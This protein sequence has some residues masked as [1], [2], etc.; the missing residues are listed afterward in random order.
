MS[1]GCAG[2][3]RDADAIEREAADRRVA[4]GVEAL[5]LRQVADV[6]DSSP[7]VDCTSRGN[8]AASPSRALP[9]NTIRLVC[10]SV[11]NS[12]RR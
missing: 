2:M 12:L 5:A 7:S 10:G 9:A 3:W 6:T 1:L 8:P 4:A 11:R